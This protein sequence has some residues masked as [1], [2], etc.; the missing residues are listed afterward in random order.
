MNSCHTL[1]I[2]QSS[3]L[4]PCAHSQAL[5]S[6]IQLLCSFALCSPSV[7][8]IFNS[9]SQITMPAHSY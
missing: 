3:F 4:R 8:A 7:S 5:T 2:H 9:G 6:Q 1:L